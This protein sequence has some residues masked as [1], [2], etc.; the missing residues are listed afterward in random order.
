[1]L[2]LVWSVAPLFGWSTYSLEKGHTSC[3]VEW[4]SR[5]WNVSSYNMVILVFAYILP[6]LIIIVSNVRLYGMVIK[7]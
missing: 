1:M 5:D 4:N 7:I 6:L 2:G 3:S